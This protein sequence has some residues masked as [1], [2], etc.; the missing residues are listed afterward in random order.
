MRQVIPEVKRLAYYATITLPE[1]RGRIEENPDLRSA[2][3]S[4][5]VIKAIICF[6]LRR[7]LPTTQF[8]QRGLEVGVG[9]SSDYFP[10]N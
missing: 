4:S 7:L 9:L 1:K 2:S 10:S 6:H 5:R 8:V 3:I